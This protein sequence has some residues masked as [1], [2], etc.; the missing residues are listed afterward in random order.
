[1]VI[2]LCVVQFWSEIILVIVILFFKIRIFGG[3]RV[4]N[5]GIDGVLFA[6]V[7]KTFLQHVKDFEDCVRSCVP[8]FSCWRKG[9][10]AQNAFQTNLWHYIFGKFR[11]NN[12]NL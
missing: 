9:S 1:M 6:G 5:G 4:C 3:S 2:Q 12:K 8:P 10:E 11:A 7:M